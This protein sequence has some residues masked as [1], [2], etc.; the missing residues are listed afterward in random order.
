MPVSMIPFKNFKPDGG[1]YGFDL[2]QALN[3]LPIHGSFRPMR[4]GVVEATVAAGP[5]TGGFVHMYQQSRAVQFLRPDGTVSNAGSWMQNTGSTLWET[6]DEVAPE[7]ASFIYVINPSSAICI[8]SLSNPVG[9]VG[10]SGHYV[11]WRYNIP[12]TPSS[13]WTVKMELLETTTV[14]AT[15]TAT[16]SA[17]TPGWVERTYTLS[18]GEIAAIVNRN[19]LRIRFTATAPGADQVSRPVEDVTVTR[20]T[21]ASSGTSDLW[22]EIDEAVASDLDYIKTGVLGV[23]GAAS[24]YRF[25]LDSNLIDPLQTSGWAI[26]FRGRNTND[27]ANLNFTAKLYSAGTLLE[28]LVLTSPDPTFADYSTSI[29]DSTI[30][31]ITDLEDLEVEISASCVSIVPVV[32]QR[33][34]PVS[35]VTNTGWTQSTGGTIFGTVDEDNPSDS[36][37]FFTN[38]AGATMRMGL[39]ASGIV[40]PQANAV[41]GYYIKVRAQASSL[42]QGFSATVREGSNVRATFQ[43]TNISGSATTYSYSFTQAEINAVSD[44]NGLTIEIVALGATTGMQVMWVQVQ[45][46]E[47]VVISISQL[48]LSAPSNVRAEVSWAEMEVPSATTVYRGDVPTTFVGTGT[49]L[50]EIANGVFSD[51]SVGGGYAANGGCWRFCSFG[52]HVVATNFVNEVQ[53]RQDNTGNFQNMIADVSPAPKARFC[54]PVHGHLVLANIN[55]AGHYA[56]EFWWSALQDVTKFDPTPTTQAGNARIVSAAGEIMGLVG[57]EYGLFFKRR[58]I[59]RLDW[60]GGQT[61]FHLREVSTSNGTPYSNSIVEADG[62]VYWWGYDGFYRYDGQRIQKVGGDAV[63][64]YL[65][66]SGYSAGGIA[67]FSP[68]T[69]AQDDQ[70]MVGW[71]DPYCGMLFWEYQG[72][73]DSLNSHRRLVV[74]NPIEDRW[75]EGDADDLWTNGRIAWAMQ[76]PNVT[77]SDTFEQK[78]SIFVGWDGTNTQL[79]RLSGKGTARATLATKRFTMGLDQG[80]RPIYATLRGI[81]PIYS[82]EPDDDNWPDISVTV[83]SANDPRFVTQLKSQTYPQS[84]ASE[85]QFLPHDNAGFFF[86]ALVEIPPMVGATVVS[87]DGLWPDYAL[88]GEG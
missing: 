58:S 11:R 88:A 57:G 49:K 6:L 86:E 30:A 26:N 64:R 42:G 5:A 71:Y 82:A 73:N 20:W 51:I 23:G 68:Q 39:T 27:G 12:W 69:I 56:D 41:A 61:V 19:N 40:N 76:Q 8:V 63:A 70:T 60:V 17:A 74:Y 7:D 29:S 38:T 45:T 87:F 25:R 31:A 36:D 47:P 79:V 22:A 34:K 37:Y 72:V 24:I 55:L 33:L 32:M 15:D 77:N 43:Q 66:D 50:Y 13:A 14:R 81:M 84:K 44:W 75:A 35:D 28:T 78:G 54:A 18:G 10:A 16:G 62:L 53:Y 80:E 65:M 48:Y 59:H 67:Q 21:D 2:K 3:V 1:K 46:P 52:N 9:S 4:K 83:Q 85:R